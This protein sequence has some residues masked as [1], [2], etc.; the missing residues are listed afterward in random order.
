MI[1]SVRRC[2]LGRIISGLNG[3]ASVALVRE[4][5]NF[6]RRKGQRGSEVASKYLCGTSWWRRQGQECCA[7]KRCGGVVVYLCPSGSRSASRS[8]SR[9]VSHRGN[10]GG[11][12]PVPA[13][14]RVR[15]G[16]AAP[17]PPGPPV[18]L[19]LHGC[20]A[21]A[22]SELRRQERRQSAWSAGT[23]EAWF[24]LIGPWDEGHPK[25][26]VPDRRARANQHRR[27]RPGPAATAR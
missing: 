22:G 4:S 23:S 18:P 17:P 19:R 10:R 7:H 1:S 14:R 5:T 20:G 2:T 26:R 24:R 16:A 11:V 21:K 27:W 8:A 12:G 9:S 25:P 6:D 13:M 3:D 15:F